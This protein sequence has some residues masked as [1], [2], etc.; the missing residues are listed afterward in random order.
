MRA[1][2]TFPLP[3]V[4]NSHLSKEA[5]KRLAWFDFFRS[6]GNNASLTC[7]YF[8]I[9]RDTFYRWKRRFNP[10]HLKTLEFDPKSRR[11]HQ[12]R[13]MQVPLGVIERIYAIRKDD[14]EKS[15]YEIQVELREQGITIGQSAIQK[16]INSYPEL[17]NTQHRKKVKKYRHYKV[18][19]IKAAK[20]L[21]EQGL[22]SLVQVDTKY[23][24]ILGNRYYLFSAVDCKSRYAFVYAYTTISS[25]SGKDFLKR[26]RD[27]FPFPIHAVNTDNGSEYLLQ[28]HKELKQAGIPHFFTDPNCPK[29]NGRVERFH[30]TV[31]YEYLNYQDLYPGINLLREHCM[32]FNQKYN[33]R[34]HHQSLGYKTPQQYV[35]ECQKGGVYGM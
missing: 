13:T 2:R 33:T 27:Y 21:R 17:T 24:S 19:R 23:F 31:E 11:P 35:L 32:V 12:V 15:K 1:F 26:V 28:F 3:A 30:Q 5:L 4:Q 25:A 18:A 14:P 34:R 8:G 29:Q 10:R 20:E 22:G 9:S 7:R 16:I 6:H